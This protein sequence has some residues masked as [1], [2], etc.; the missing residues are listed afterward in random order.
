VLQSRWGPIGVDGASAA[1]AAPTDP[2]DVFR[3][4]SLRRQRR[5]L[6]SESADEAALRLRR[7]RHRR[8]GL[9]RA[10]REAAQADGSFSYAASRDGGAGEF[11]GPLTAF[12]N[13]QLLNSHALIISEMCYRKD[14]LLFEGLVNF[15][16]V[17]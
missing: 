11:G 4:R 6:L 16:D 10:A 5:G 13:A 12:R 17:G 2:E 9:Q 7:R 1:D 15:V 14:Q 8:S 3:S